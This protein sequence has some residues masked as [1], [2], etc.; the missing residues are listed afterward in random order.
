MPFVNFNG[1]ICIK[2]ETLIPLHSRA[3]R[4]GEGLIETMFFNDK[5][6]GLLKLHYERLKA[7][8]ETLHFPTISFYDFEKEIAKT[9]IANQNPNK[10]ILRAEFFM[11]EALHELQ[12]WIEHMPV[13]EGHALWK[14]EG[15]KIG[16]TTSLVKAPDAISHLK[17]TSRLVYVMA[18]QEAIKND[19]DDIL[20]T[21]PNGNIVESTISNVFALKGNTIYTP[22]LS[23]G[24]VAG[25]M[26][27]YLLNQK[28]IGSLKIEEKIIDAAFITDAD[29]VFLTNAVRGIQPVHSF[30]NK[31]Y[32]Q[33]ATRFVF[34]TISA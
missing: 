26:R 22:P 23:E 4:Y 18:K 16:L 20:L 6:I 13:K 8:L 1:L 30:E 11:N 24:C 32:A 17:H 34:D 5:R 15:L 7:G 33:D 28:E 12:F 29:E 31:V 19:W 25:V 10:G 2:D 3:L 21:N 14:E 27:Q 9:I